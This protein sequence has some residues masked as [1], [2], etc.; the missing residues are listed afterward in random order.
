MEEIM[1]PQD[2]QGAF[3]ARGNAV[4]ELRRLVEEHEG[5][6][7]PAEVRQQIDRIHEDIS[8]LDER[9]R[10]GLD[11]LEREAKAQA[12]M[13][14]FRQYGDL[15]EAPESVRDNSGQ[16]DENVMFAKLCTGEVRSFESLP[17]EQRDLTKGSA[18]AGGNI[19]DSTMYDRIWDKL[20]EESMVIRAGATVIRTASGEDLLVPKVTANTTVSA[21]TAEAGAISEADP[22]FGQV[23]LGAYKYAGLTQVSQELLSDSMFNV[24]GFVADQGGRAVARGFG[25]DLSNGSG[26]SKPKGIAQAATSFG[27]SA[28]ATTITAA[29]IFEVWS[30]MPS[31]YR[32][33]DTK[34]IMSPEAEKTI[35]LLTDSNNQ[36]LWQP[37]LQNG[38]PS[39]LLGYEVFV[40][41][42]IDA[43]TSGKR[44]LVFAHMPSYAVRIAGGLQVDRSDDYA[45]NAGLATFRFQIRGDGDGIDSNGI[46]CL[47]QA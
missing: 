4:V 36:Y 41:G 33:S 43:V 27:T 46:G 42:H 35:R 7:T 17:S 45:F 19:V 31:P 30:T 20:E 44:A 12:A 28:S 24:A 23:T 26:S 39:N 40:D 5:Q 8:A 10:T 34:W 6:E 1:T 9:I 3:D 38:T 15:T 47:T 37:G 13:D 32:N 21:I 11:H 2:I 14:E 18:T 29:N 22:V 16:V 25:A